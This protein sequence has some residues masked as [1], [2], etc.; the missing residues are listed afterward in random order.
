MAL[1]VAHSCRDRRSAVILD[2]VLDALAIVAVLLAIG[3]GGWLLDLR[4]WL[5]DVL[6]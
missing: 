1:P 5:R 4:D 2:L 3:A 6:G